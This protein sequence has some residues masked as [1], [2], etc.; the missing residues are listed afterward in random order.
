M[1]YFVLLALLGLINKSEAIR[2]TDIPTEDTA[3][4]TQHF[5]QMAQEDSSI[6]TDLNK[7]VDQA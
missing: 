4:V 6:M 1:K 3:D 7:K 5:Q 2:F